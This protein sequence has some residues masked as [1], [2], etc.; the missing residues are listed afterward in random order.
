[1]NHI[2]QNEYLTLTVSSRGAEKQTLVSNKKVH[3]LRSK[4]ALWD[5]TAPFL[6]PNVGRLR[7]GLTFINGVE[8]HLPQHGFLRDQEFEV[9]KSEK[10]EIS[11]IN[12]YNEETLKLFPFKYKA[13]ITYSLKKKTLRT[14]VTIVNEDKEDLFFNFG[15]HPGFICPLYEGEKFED[16]KIVFE[17]A[18]NF[19]APSVEANGTLNYNTPSGTYTNLKELPLDYK[20][21]ETDAIVIPRVRSKKVSLLNAK[22]QGIEFKYPDFITLAIWTKPNAGFVCLEPWIGHADR[23]DGNHQFISK[24]NIIT[25]KQLEEFKI[26]YDI[27][28]LD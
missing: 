12:V 1:M 23:C 17:K 8:Y 18:E 19:S 6:F 3:Y 4:D 20:Y 22:H 13:I 21:F 11:L 27:T 28:I 10:S 16:Y 14:S 5:R 9:L 26:Y 25:L 15:G 24:D 7:D 2:I